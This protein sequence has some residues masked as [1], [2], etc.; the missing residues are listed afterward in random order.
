MFVYR[1]HSEL[2][3]LN[4]YQHVDVVKSERFGVWQLT[5]FTKAD[6]TGEAFTREMPAYAFATFTE[7]IEA[8]YAF[9]HLYSALE[10]G[11]MAWNPHEV[12]SFSDL[13][14]K[15]KEFLSTQP[16]KPSFVPLK[17]LDA[18]TLKITGLREI[19]IENIRNDRDLS[20]TDREK[21]SVL[22]KLKN[23]LPSVD[24]MDAVTWEIKW[25]NC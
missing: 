19:T 24:P 18:L 1:G 14:S 3:N 20:I 21:E 9:C 15:V 25:E 6:V 13:W 12:E 17:V 8:R 23:T 7:E 16:N 22:I 11:K 10:T 4:G 5:A 2:I